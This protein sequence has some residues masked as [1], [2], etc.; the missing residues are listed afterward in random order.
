MA[1]NKMIPVLG[2]TIVLFF[3]GLLSAEVMAANWR[4]PR[5]GPLAF[6]HGQVEM[7]VDAV[8]ELDVESVSQQDQ[9]DSQQDQIC[10]LYGLA[11]VE[12]PLE[13]FSIMPPICPW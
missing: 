9:L 3:I 6:L 4:F 7:L 5:Q 12:L 8:A 1:R 11:G 13:C 10:E 2:V